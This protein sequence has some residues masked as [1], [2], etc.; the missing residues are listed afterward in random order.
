MAMSEATRVNKRAG[1]RI[2]GVIFQV[3]ALLSLIGTILATAAVIKL[4]IFF[5]I[6][7]SNNVPAWITFLIGLFVT[8]VLGGL[9]YTLGI[10]CAIYDRQE[11]LSSDGVN[12]G[13]GTPIRFPNESSPS[14]PSHIV[15]N[16][17]VA[18]VSS[19]PSIEP[20]PQPRQADSGSSESADSE[21]GPIWE[22]LIRERHFGQT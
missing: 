19:R 20:I 7:G 9:G 22:W 12:R 14:R 8:C 10:L 17:E 21:K 18:P 13:E 4:G 16:S 2:L 3:L 1:A 15:V 6:A 11:S 5:N